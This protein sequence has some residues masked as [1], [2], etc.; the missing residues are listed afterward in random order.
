VALDVGDDVHFAAESVDGF[1]F[2]EGL[3]CGDRI[4]A[5]FDVYLGLEG[6]DQMDGGKFVE[7][8]HVVDTAEGRQQLCT[9]ILGHNG[10]AGVFVGAHGGVG[11]YGYHKDVA[12]SAGGLQI[13]QVAN[14][15]HIEGAVGQY[16]GFAFG[17]PAEAEGKQFRESDYSVCDH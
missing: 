13:A 14:M 9:L 5:A 7:D 2:G 8:G 10:P 1:G 16:E 15:E 17:A 12:Q 11:V 6:F 3:A 4:V